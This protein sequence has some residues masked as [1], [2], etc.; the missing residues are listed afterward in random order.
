[1]DFIG[2]LKNGTDFDE[3]N[4]E[5]P[6]TNRKIYR[7][8]SYP[9]EFILMKSEGPR[10]DG[11]PTKP[12]ECQ[13]T[14]KVLKERIQGQ[15]KDST[16]VFPCPKTTS[17]SSTKFAHLAAFVQG[18]QEEAMN[19]I[20]KSAEGLYENID[21]QNNGETAKWYLSSRSTS[22]DKI[23]NWVHLRID[24]SPK[25]YQYNPYKTM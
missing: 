3:Y 7:N 20:L 8:D 13:N 25:Y 11:V 17:A 15:E 9:F 21:N 2:A 5:C 6:P 4:I 22:S 16:L 19:V 23:T 10:S 1:M 24:P 18:D 12:A 14:I